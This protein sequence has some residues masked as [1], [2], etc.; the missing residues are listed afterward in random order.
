[1]NKTEYEFWNPSQTD[2]TGLEF[3]ANVFDDSILP[4]FDRDLVHLWDGDGCQIAIR[5]SRILTWSSPKAST[6]PP[7]RHR[8][9]V[10]AIASPHGLFAEHSYLQRGEERS[11]QLGAAL[12]RD[13]L[14]NLSRVARWVAEQFDHRCRR[15]FDGE[16][17]VSRRVSV[18]QLRSLP[19][20]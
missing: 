19:A 2:Q 5:R 8:R 3:N 18:A 20:E 14:V 15:R 16:D 6:D 9:R 7:Q 11:E 10:K 4:V 12:E 17:R 1:M 13:V